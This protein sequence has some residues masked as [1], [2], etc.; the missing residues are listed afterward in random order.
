MQSPDNYIFPLI[1]CG[2][3]HITDIL[4]SNVYL[5]ECDLFLSDRAARGLLFYLGEPAL[6]VVY[7]SGGRLNLGLNT[8]VWVTCNLV[9]ST[10]HREDDILFDTQCNAYIM[11]GLDFTLNVNKTDVRYE[12]T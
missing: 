8:K 10:L 1:L 6:L 5:L 2:D 7:M 3:D 4:S 9:L 11:C 12:H